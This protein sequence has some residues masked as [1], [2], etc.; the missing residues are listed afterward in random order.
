MV[1][2]DITRYNE[3]LRSW[4]LAP[5]F[6]ASLELLAEIG[7]LFVIGPEAL[8]ER[9]Q[10]GGAGGGGGGGVLAGLG[11]ERRELKLFLMRREDSATIGVQSVI[12]GL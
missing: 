1:S 11:A 4:P 2:K 6:V 8:K 7:N 12:A 5:G 3:L 9:L 10:R